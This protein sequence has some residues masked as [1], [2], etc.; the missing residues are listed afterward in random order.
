MLGIR[1]I[2]V[3]V[4][5]IHVVSGALYGEK[6]VGEGPDALLVGNFDGN[7]QLNNNLLYIFNN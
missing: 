1:S 2:S 5:C 3:L 6:C 7:S 4:L